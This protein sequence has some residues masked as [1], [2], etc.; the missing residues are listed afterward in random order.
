MTKKMMNAGWA[1]EL[2]TRLISTTFVLLLL[3]RTKVKSNRGVLPPWHALSLTPIKPYPYYVAS[4][5]RVATDMSR[6]HKQLKQGR[7]FKKKE[8]KQGRPIILGLACA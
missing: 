6:S 5:S 1:L 4:R 3:V 8:R 2:L 7:R